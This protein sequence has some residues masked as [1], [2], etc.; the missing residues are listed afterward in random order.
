MANGREIEFIITF[1]KNVRIK[2][3]DGVNTVPI[4]D[5]YPTAVLEGH[6]KVEELTWGQAKRKYRRT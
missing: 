2:K 3:I 6:R 4:Q 1:P 5:N